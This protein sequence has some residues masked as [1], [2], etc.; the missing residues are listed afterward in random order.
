MSEVKQV[1]TVLKRHLKAKGLTYRDVGRA[2][3]IG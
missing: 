2:I 1:L 3:G